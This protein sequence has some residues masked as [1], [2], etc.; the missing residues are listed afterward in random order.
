MTVETKTEPA[1][2]TPPAAA[3]PAPAVEGE[4]GA[5]AAPDAGK[6]DPNPQGAKPGEAAPAAKGDEATPLEVTLPEGF[7]L[8]EEFA[9]LAKELGLKGAGAQKLADLG[10]KAVQAAFAQVEAQ[11]KSE[12]EGWEKAT[13]EDP[14][15]GGAKF[16]ATVA[17]AKKGLAS[18][19]PAF[20]EFLN[21]SGLGSHPEMVRYAAWVG[22]KV[23]EDR[24][25]GAG[26]GAATGEGPRTNADRARAR[27]DK[28][29][30]K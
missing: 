8:P 13:K 16:E 25:P 20:V 3:T 6:T 11:R 10:V 28:S 23:A 15:I 4:K 19:P 18:A 24:L 7:T 22:E 14:A 26:R 12:V 29:I 17:L 27:F 1:A 9:P 21:Q 2:V 30:G 5:P